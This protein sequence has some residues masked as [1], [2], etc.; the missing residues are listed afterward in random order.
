MSQTS[1]SR[2]ESRNSLY[3]R[4][5]PAVSRQQSSSSSPLAAVTSIIPKLKLN[6]TPQKAGTPQQRPSP[7]VST[8][9]QWQHPRMD[10]VIKRKNATNFDGSNVRVIRLNAAIIIASFLLPI[11][12]R[13]AYASLSTTITNAD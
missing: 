3:N 7:A 13:S 6:L 9:G 5:T 4:L 10:E 2:N 12:T 11:L 1:L 8:P